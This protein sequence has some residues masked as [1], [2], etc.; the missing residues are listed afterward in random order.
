VHKSEQKE[1]GLLSAAIVIVFFNK[2]ATAKNF[3]GAVVAS[4]KPGDIFYPFS[5][6]DLSSCGDVSLFSSL[7]IFLKILNRVIVR[8]RIICSKPCAL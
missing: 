4:S 1:P 6:L 8:E 3:I 7:L 2:Q 5:T